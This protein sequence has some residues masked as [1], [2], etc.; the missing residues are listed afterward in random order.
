MAVENFLRKYNVFFVFLIMAVAI[1]FRL[2]NLASIPPGLYPD[3]AING[4][5]AIEALDTGNYKIFYPENN[6]RE[7]LFINIQSFFIK[8]FGNEPWALRF[9]SAIFGSFTILGLYL[10]TKQL[11]QKESTAMLAAFFMAVSFWHINFSRIGF[12]AIMA[13]FFLVWS[14]WLFW[15]LANSGAENRKNKIIALFAGIIFG[16]GFHS[17]IAYRITPVLLIPAGIILIKKKQFYSLLLFFIGAGLAI[18]PLALYF[19]QNPQDFFGRT[20]QISVFSSETIAKDISINIAK[21]FGMFFAV[22]DYNWRHNLAGAPQLW[23]PISALFA[24]GIIL[25][26]IQIFKNLEIRK[27]TWGQKFLSAIAQFSS[28]E[29]FLFIWMAAGFLPVII[30]NEGLP[31]ALRAIILIP[32]SM[33]FAALGFVW[34][35]QKILNWINLMIEKYPDFSDQVKRIKKEFTVFAFAFLIM[36]CIQAYRQYFLQWAGSPYVADAFSQNYKNLGEYLNMAPRNMKK[37]VIVNTGGTNVRGTPMPSQ[38]T[39]FITNTFTPE[40][41]TEKNI[42]YITENNIDSFIKT[43]KAEKIFQIYYLE[44]CAQLRRKFRD[45]IPELY[46]FI[47]YGMVIQQK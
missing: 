18:S 22:G 17:Y 13:P 26:I 33:I 40:K 43:A 14:M 3:E 5:N 2:F 36:L 28:S 44:N 20:S 19:Y 27:K 35:K 37:Y 29:M 39:M 4:N 25:S 45:A 41:Q 12:R 38:T 46:S 24:L 7:G 9:T 15:K 10:L 11:F 47:D 8:I 32:P 6:G 23:Y 16:L 1:F 30:S 21:T 34:L 31:H 42:Y